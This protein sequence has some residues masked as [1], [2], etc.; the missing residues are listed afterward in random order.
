MKP[1]A[2]GGGA[3]SVTGFTVSREKG[4]W[5][6]SKLFMVWMGKL[7]LSWVRDR[8]KVKAVRGQTQS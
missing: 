3:G 4:S 2:G 6:L 1:M 5:K 8:A 7:R